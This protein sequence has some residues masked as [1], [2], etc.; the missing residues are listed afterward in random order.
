M[1]LDSP[2]VVHFLARDFSRKKVQVEDAVPNQIVFLA[3]GAGLVEGEAE[4]VAVIGFLHPALGELAGELEILIGFGLSAAHLAQSGECAE[5]ADGLRAEVD[6]VRQV[7]GEIVGAKLVLRIETFRL[8]IFSPL[9]ELL[10]VESGEIGVAFHLRDDGHEDEQI[11]ALL[12]RHLVF[13]I[14]LAAAI[15]LAVR[16]GIRAEVVRREWELPAVARR[17]IHERHEN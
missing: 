7:A 12:H 9:L 2:V 13:L 15:D 3:R 5:A 4:M 10:P 16:L 14:A 1:V 8:E 6:V 17:V 11:A